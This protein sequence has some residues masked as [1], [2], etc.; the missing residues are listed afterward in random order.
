MLMENW[1][2]MLLLIDIEEMMLIMLT[3]ELHVLESWLLTLNIGSGDC[4][5]YLEEGKAGRGDPG[6]RPQHP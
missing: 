1:S 4:T 6:T 2:M 3:G 5:C